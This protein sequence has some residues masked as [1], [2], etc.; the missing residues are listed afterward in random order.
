M[1]I[2]AEFLILAITILAIAAVGLC[3]LP[4]I[5]D[6]VSS[7]VEQ[8]KEKRLA[9]AS[10]RRAIK[11][12]EQKLLAFHQESLRKMEEKTE[13]ILSE[14]LKAISGNHSES[15]SQLSAAIKNDYD[16][17]RQELKAVTDKYLGETKIALSGLVPK[18][19]KRVD[20]ELT[21]QL[22]TTKAELADYK[23]QQIKKVDDEVAVLVEKTIYKTLGK[24]LC[25]KDQTA[26]IYEALAEAK[27]EGFFDRRAQ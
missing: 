25:Q 10:E 8:Q 11:Q 17:N 15:L 27:E 22:Q 1:L 3:Y 21:K 6:V 5:S 4:I 24:T 2:S 20:E 13:K 23:K 7:I 12:V 9:R 26:L 19:E 14:Q 16:Q 18:A